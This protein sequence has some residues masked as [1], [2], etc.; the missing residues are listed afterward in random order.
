MSKKH[1][2]ENDRLRAG[3][4]LGDPFAGT[5]PVQLPDDASADTPEASPASGE[6]ATTAG[7]QATQ[8]EPGRRSLADAMP[9]ALATIL[10]RVRGEERPTPTPWD[11]LNEKLCGGLWPG[12]YTFTSGTGVGKTQ[13]AIQVAVEA[14]KQELFDAAIAYRAAHGQNTN[15]QEVGWREILS[16][17][18]EAAASG[19]P[20]KMRPVIYVALELGELDM[21]ARVASLLAPSTVANGHPKWS[22]LA[23]GRIK[24]EAVQYLFEASGELLSAL[25]IEI[26]VAPPMGWDSDRLDAFASANPRM[27]IVDFLQLVRRKKGEEAR[28]A[29]GRVSYQ[30]R[31]L[32]RDHGTIVLALSST[33]RINY[34]ITKGKGEN[35]KEA[36]PW[37][38]DPTSFVGLG[39]ESGDI[40]YACDGV[41]V[42][43][44]E[45]RDPKSPTYS[46]DPTIIHL[47]ISKQRGL[48]PAWVRDLRFDGGH[49]YQVARGKTYI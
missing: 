3:I 34:S 20:L 12:F 44:A 15:A 24:E 45:P 25:P 2:D 42:M 37:D 29:V 28:E 43:L 23:F 46:T 33:A 16:T 49:F 30:A 39:K 1:P 32:A 27:V 5:V 21:V 7:K 19:E 40:E 35:S 17:W 47:A 22:D 9:G 31:R 14:A 8:G 10:R 38:Q 18:R 6:R 48:S 13:W 36:P 41:L 26:E 11:S 4:P